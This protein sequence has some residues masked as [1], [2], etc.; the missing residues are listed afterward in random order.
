MMCAFDFGDPVNKAAYVTGTILLAQ[1]N[2]YFMTGVSAACITSPLVVAIATTFFKKGFTEDE[3]AAGIVN[4]ILGSTHITEGAIPFVAKDP[5]R[6]IPIMM[7]GSSISAILSYVLLITVPAPH[8]GFLILPLVNK[9]LI[10]VLFILAGASVGAILMGMLYRLN[11]E[12]K[13]NKIHEYNINN[14]VTNSAKDIGENKA[15]VSFDSKNTYIITGE[16][17]KTAVLKQIAEDMKK[18]GL[19]DVDYFDALMKREDQSNTYLEKGI[20]IPHGSKDMANSVLKTGFVVK[21]IP[22]GVDWNNGNIVKLAIGIAANNQNHLAL[23]SKITTLL[24]DSQIEDKIAHITTIEDLLDLLSGDY[25]IKPE[26]IKL[27]DTNV[28]KKFSSKIEEETFELLNEHGLHTRP[29]SLLIKML[30]SEFPDHTITFRKEKKSES[31]NAKSIMQLTK[32]GIKKGDKVIVNVSGENSK[33]ALERIKRMF[34]NKFGE[35]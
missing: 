8:G 27:K 16:T 1:G 35:Q 29:C 10:W 23:L 22:D 21:F 17:T 2:Y 30:K 5:I 26:V 6:M 19:V 31:V 14:K 33:N 15:P 7:T 13:T 11:T 20:A 24:S 4:Y 9:P 32:L 34:E 28:D 18:Q 25:V 3:R 12:R